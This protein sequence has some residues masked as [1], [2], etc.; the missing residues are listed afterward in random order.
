MGDTMMS[1]MDNAI[2]NV[3]FQNN[4]NESEIGS[5]NSLNRLV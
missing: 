1:K 2:K 5:F 3:H 4:D